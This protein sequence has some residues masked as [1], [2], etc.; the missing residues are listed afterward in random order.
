M[1]MLVCKERPDRPLQ[2]LQNAKRRLDDDRDA[3]THIMGR[4]TYEGMASFWPT[5]S[6]DY[7]AS[8]NEITK[9]VDL[10]LVAATTFSTGAMRHVYEPRGWGAQA[11]GWVRSGAPAPGSCGSERIGGSI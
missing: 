10:N 8:M 6:D 7:A 5:A 3:G 11:G 4:V 1:A 2:E 9:V